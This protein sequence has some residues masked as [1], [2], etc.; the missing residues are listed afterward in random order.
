MVLAHFGVAVSLFGMASESTFT[1]E[2]LVAARVGD[3]V[4]VGPWMV[5]LERLEPVAGP[6]WTALE[7]GLLAQRGDGAADILAPQARNFWT[8][9]QNTSEAALL[10]TWDGQLYAVVGE[11]AEGGRWQLRLWWK[12]FVTFIWYG[13]ILIALGGAMALAGRL[14]GERRRRENDEAEWPAEAPA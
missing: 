14:L 5:T 7:A 2:K 12:P 8:P 11:E 4:A 9:P 3:E 6:N 13:G 10:T 1:T